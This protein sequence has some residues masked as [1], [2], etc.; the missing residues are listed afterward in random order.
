MGIYNRKSGALA[1]ISAFLLSVPAGAVTQAEFLELCLSGSAESVAEALQ[2]SKISA[3]TADSK[4]NTPLMMASQSKGDAADPVKIQLIVARGG[5]PA[6][7]NK[8]GLT[9]LGLAARATDN[10]EIIVELVRAGANLE[11]KTSRGWTALSIA[12]ARNPNPAIIN[13]L[14]DLGADLNVLD[15]QQSSPLMLAAR[16]GNT[17]GVINALLDNGADPLLQNPQ[18]KIP[19][20]FLDAKKYTPEEL[21]VLK[22]RL[23]QENPPS[24]AKP[25]RFAEA[26]R[27]GIEPRIRY[28]LQARTDPNAFSGTQSPLLIAASEN[29]WPGVI[30]TLIQYGA[31][32]DIRD[33]HGRTPLICAARSG[34]NPGALTELLLSGARPDFVD[35]DG[36]N[37][38]DYATSNPAF[39]SQDLQLL[40]SM[41]NAVTEAEKRGAQKEID[42]RNADETEPAKMT[43]LGELYSRMAA[44]Q[45]WIVRLADSAAQTRREAAETF[46]NERAAQIQASSLQERL[47]EEKQLTQSLK[48][49]LENLKEVQ[50]KDTLVA[51]ENSDRL[52]A[53]WQGEMQKNLKLAAEN[54]EDFQKQ[55]EQFEA[56]IKRIED[57]THAEIED[58]RARLAEET[59]KVTHA[60]EDLIAAEQRYKE[61]S[62]AAQGRYERTLEENKREYD[63][64]T[65]TLK[66][67]Q[68]KELD[69]TLASLSEKH[70]SEM[71]S[72]A[73]AAE[74][75]EKAAL[76]AERDRHVEEMT[77]Q[78]LQV[79]ADWSSQ[80]AK[81]ETTKNREIRQKTD[82]LL[83][84]TTSQK[85][86][87]ADVLTVLNAFL[88]RERDAS[89]KARADY[90]ALKT[91]SDK[92]KAAMQEHLKR[93]Q[94]MSEAELNKRLAEQEETLR[95]EFAAESARLKEEYRNQLRDAGAKF[96]AQVN[97]E[98]SRLKAQHE[99]ELN[100]KTTEL[101]EII[102]KL[103]ATPVPADLPQ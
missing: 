51:R 2:D 20:D 41:L 34:R 73:A 46:K 69:G 63:R 9:S 81:L 53:L 99:K 71:Q 101:Y 82:E 72:A 65:D 7:R 47:D 21:E 32:A 28:F 45:S 38:L 103:K 49:E 33:E 62:T 93:Q 90:S 77:R 60:Q 100:E 40:T 89:A 24:P 57:T 84:E 95:T 102:E 64:L 8:E 79:D 31:N 39:S 74:T 83:Q 12:A 66:E 5:K 16:S 55:K 70:A 23:K 94:I 52:T 61:E 56:A 96:E 37:A 92:E 88:R 30:P 36:K 85:I 87:F 78:R 11:E 27:N 22:T 10:P 4:G 29:P 19:G 43:H 26:C 1:L 59:E 6:T 3:T 97:D 15:G 58:L 76:Q 67:R 42:R 75:H 25:E 44:D 98:I 80:L 54:T 13:V 18:A 14:S 17:A 35:N 50:R 48:E 91:R 68:Q 86:Q